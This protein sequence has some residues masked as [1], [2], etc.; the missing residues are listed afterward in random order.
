M[1]DQSKDQVTEAAQAL[2]ELGAAKGGNARA[3][4][5]SPEER[6]EIARIAAEKRWGNKSPQLPKETHEGILK[7]A[8]REI[9]VSVLDNG[10]RVFSITGLNRA[11]GSRMK[12][13]GRSGIDGS[14]QLPPFLA[15]ASLRSFISNDLLVPLMSPLLYKPKQGGRAA[16]GYEATILPQICEVILDAA[17]AGVLRRRSSKLVQAAEILLRGFARV[18]I[19]ALIDEATGYQADR[20]RDELNKILEAY[21]SKE[22]LPWTERFPNEFFKQLYRV[23]GWDYREGNPKRYRVVGKL[24]NKYVYEPMPPGVLE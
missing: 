1:D 16:V 9:P 13:G 24:I 21:I 6:R 5:L 15:K 4:A 8:D 3:A 10:T 12:G 11:I 17:K 19:I 20:A 18:G 2:S 14:F 23:R 22:L 7:I